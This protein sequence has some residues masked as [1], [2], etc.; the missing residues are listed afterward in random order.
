[1]TDR[2]KALR[3][4]A[5]GYIVGALPWWDIDDSLKADKE[6]AGGSVREIVAILIKCGAPAELV[7]G[8]EALGN[9]N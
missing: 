3:R 7:Q 5:H 6:L 2:E 8:L 9:E 1:M 4:E